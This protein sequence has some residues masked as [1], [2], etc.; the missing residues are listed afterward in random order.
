MRE[1]HLTIGINA[2]GIDVF[3]N[4]ELQHAYDKFRKASS[5]NPKTLIDLMTNLGSTRVVGPDDVP[6]RLR[7]QHRV[8]LGVRKYHYWTAVDVALNVS[9]S[10]DRSFWQQFVD[11]AIK[12][13]A[14][15]A[16]PEITL[17]RFYP[18]SSALTMKDVAEQIA[19]DARDLGH[20]SSGSACQCGDSAAS[21]NGESPST[22]R[23]SPL[24]GLIWM[25]SGSAFPALGCPA[26][27]YARSNNRKR[28][29]RNISVFALPLAVLSHMC[30]DASTKL[31]VA[32]VSLPI[33]SSMLTASLNDRLL[34]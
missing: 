24:D 26:R 1:P 10:W 6:W 16:A 8:K 33:H 22:D 23:R 25:E 17:G 28:G 20:I 27:S 11:E 15:E 7:V 29:P 21:T 34:L 9:S 19:S 30:R 13:F 2:S 18:A 4:V 31:Y 12:P 32:R 14:D 3:A 5:T